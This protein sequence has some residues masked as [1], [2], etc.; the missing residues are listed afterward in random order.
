MK[1]DH[2]CCSLKDIRS[3]KAFRRVQ[4]NPHK[5]KC[6]LFSLSIMSLTFFC[7]SPPFFHYIE[8]WLRS[9]RYAS[10]TQIRTASEKFAVKK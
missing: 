1:E 5:L 6:V 9:H 4:S 3:N 10:D 7:L 8:T 2:T